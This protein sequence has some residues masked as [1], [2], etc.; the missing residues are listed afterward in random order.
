MKSE[1]FSVWLSAI[2]GMSEAQR[3]LKGLAAL[4]RGRRAGRGVFKAR[5]RASRTEDALG[6]AGVER[7]ERQGCPHGAGRDIAAGAVR[8]GFCGFAARAAG[9]R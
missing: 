1:D 4:E 3:K 5:R 2:S 6:T 7:V 8:M 9:A